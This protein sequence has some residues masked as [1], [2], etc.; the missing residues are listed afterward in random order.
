MARA[1][2]Y[3]YDAAPRFGK[4]PPNDK[5]YAVNREIAAADAALNRAASAKNELQKWVDWGKGELTPEE[6]QQLSVGLA[7]YQQTARSALDEAAA[8]IEA[9]RES[10]KALVGTNDEQ[11]T[12][13]R[14]T[15]LRNRHDRLRTDVESAAPLVAHANKAAADDEKQDAEKEKKAKVDKRV[16]HVTAVAGVV[17]KVA[18]D[19]TKSYD[20]ASS[21]LRTAQQNAETTRKAQIQAATANLAQKGNENV[22]AVLV[23]EGTKALGLADAVRRAREGAAHESEATMRSIEEAIARV[24]AAETALRG[25]VE[26]RDLTRLRTE[27]IQVAAVAVAW[28]EK[29]DRDMDKEPT[30]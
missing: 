20:A 30:P 9:A 10:A 12:I 3:T 8:A 4:A 14:L 25:V 13:T 24:A 5:M 21:L 27:L 18:G 28:V 1:V 29:L 26:E 17:E 22:D 15:S 2:L 6:R 19:V 23:A 16:E 11:T 7:G